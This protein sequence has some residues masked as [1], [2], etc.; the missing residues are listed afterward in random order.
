MATGSWL[1][2]Q[3]SWLMPR[4]SWLKAHGSWARKNLALGP[5]GPGPS[6]K[7]FLAMGHVPPALK[8]EP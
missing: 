1:M 8:Q 2:A 3:G 4:G 5:P 7:L 6:A